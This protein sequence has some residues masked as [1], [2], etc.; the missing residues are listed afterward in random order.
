MHYKYDC[1]QISVELRFVEL[2]FV[3]PRFLSQYV[4]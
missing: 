3:E 1:E 2:V 4:C